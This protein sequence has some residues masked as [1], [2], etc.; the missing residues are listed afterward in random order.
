MFLFFKLFSF[1]IL[2]LFF[3]TCNCLE[4]LTLDL[5]TDSSLCT[6][7]IQNKVLN[8]TTEPRVRYVSTRLVKLGPF[9][10]ISSSTDVF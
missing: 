9:K 6:S 7:E 10:N 1:A 8:V 5:Q 4:P 3:S 2:L